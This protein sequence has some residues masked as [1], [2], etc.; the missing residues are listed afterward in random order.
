MCR[1]ILLDNLRFGTIL[2]YTH[3]LLH[4]LVSHCIAPWIRWLFF[5]FLKRLRGTLGLWT[6][7]WSFKLVLQLM[8]HL[9]ANDPSRMVFEHFRDCFHSEDSANG[10]LLV[11]SILLSYCIKPYSTSNC[12]C[13]WRNSCFNHDQT[14]R[15]SSS[16]YNGGNLVSVHKSL[17]MFSISWRLCNTFLP[18]PIQSC[19]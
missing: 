18:K 12:I 3:I 9:L 1:G 2:P 17:F 6:F 11:V 7:F 15:W 5:I 8:L 13:F 14:F 19:N 4:H 10:F 16:Y